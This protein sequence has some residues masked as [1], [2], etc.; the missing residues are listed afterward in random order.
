MSYTALL[1]KMNM[2]HLYMALLALLFFIY[3]MVLSET[4]DFIFPHHN[5]E[6]YDWHIAVEM[7]GEIGVAYLIY[8]VLQ[9]HID[10]IL[11]YILKREIPYSKHIFLIAFSFG[12]YKHLK[13]SEKKADYFKNKIMNLYKNRK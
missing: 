3:G 5:E 10:G 13:K 2:D 9:T 8:F 7:F 12:I 4:I 6:K 11:F 1:Q